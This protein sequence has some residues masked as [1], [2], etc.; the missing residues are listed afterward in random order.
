MKIKTALP[1]VIITLFVVWSIAAVR[2]DIDKIDFAQVWLARDAI[3]IAT[4]LSLFNYVLRIIRWRLYLS[5]SR[6][7]LPVRFT[8]LTYL[9]GFA[10]TLSPG[11]VGEMVRGR[12]YHEIGVPFSVTTA[13][14]F[15]ERL[16]DL[17]A[18]LALMFLAFSTFSSYKTLGWILLVVIALMAVIL[19]TANWRA[20]LRSVEDASHIPAS[21][22]KAIE[23]ILRILLSA[24]GL[25]H[26]KLIVTGFLLGLLAWGAE[27][28]GL[29]AIGKLVP[30][31]SMEWPVATGIYSVAIIAGAVSFFPG[32]LGGTE[33]V[34]TAMLVSHGYRMPDAILLTFVC[35]I[36]TLWFAVLIG[37]IAVFLLRRDH[38]LE[39]MT[40]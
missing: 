36:L 37:W 6:H 23:A 17:F 18:M 9:A 40:R 11:K 14:F 30:A 8:A 28:I 5:H 35:R 1:Y 38:Q 32:G 10:F 19:A 2:N 20:L 39:I 3:F 12:Y 26:P 16:M 4:M 25:L 33:T 22:K 21:L 13:A 31:V 15:V 34:M 27:G 7:S 24:K 29:A